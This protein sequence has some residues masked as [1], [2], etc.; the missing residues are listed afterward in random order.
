MIRQAI[1][2]RLSD[3]ANFLATR[4]VFVLEFIS[5]EKRFL[6]FVNVRL[7]IGEV[8]PYDIYKNLP[9]KVQLE[10]DAVPNLSMRRVAHYPFSEFSV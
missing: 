2:V 10:I 3:S 9:T 1:T 7:V 4:A 8:V 6:Y 5:G